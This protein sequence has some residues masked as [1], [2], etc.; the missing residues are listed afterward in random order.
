MTSFEHDPVLL[1]VSAIVDKERQLY[2]TSILSDTINDLMLLDKT[3]EVYGAWPEYESLAE[4]MVNEV[5]TATHAYIDS[6]YG[7]SADQDFRLE[8]AHIF[9][10][11]MKSCINPILDAPI[12]NGD[13]IDPISIYSTGVLKYYTASPIEEDAFCSLQ[14]LN[15]RHYAKSSAKSYEELSNIEEDSG[16][17]KF[18]IAKGAGGKLPKLRRFISPLAWAKNVRERRTR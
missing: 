1:E 2:A 8:V 7:R 3:A 17:E 14:E 11:W 12:F 9:D 4:T 10:A 6:Y 13:G 15:L 18:M 16:F 5:F